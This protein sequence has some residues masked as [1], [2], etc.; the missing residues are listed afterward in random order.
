MHF[1]FCLQSL[2]QETIKNETAV[3]KVSGTTTSMAGPESGQ[4]LHSLVPGTVW[5]PKTRE[6]NMLCW[7]G[8][9]Q[10]DL[11]PG[12]IITLRSKNQRDPIDLQLRIAC[13]SL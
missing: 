7:S 10:V 5:N 1:A 13:D 8:K 11:S 9:K 3:Q 2:L 6:Q 4:V 12:Q